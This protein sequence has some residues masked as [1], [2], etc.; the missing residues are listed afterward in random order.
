[1]NNIITVF[2]PVYNR[3]D[4]LLR[5]YESLICQTN[6]NFEWVICDDCSKDGTYEQ[7]KEWE[8]NET[9]F[10]IKVIKSATNGGKHRAINLGIK[11]AQGFMFFI[12]DS[13][14]CLTENAIQK[15]FDWEKTIYGDL[16]F[17]GL[18]F[19]KAD[20]YE[21]CVGTTFEGLIC[22]CTSLEREMNCITGDKAEVFYTDVIK[23]YP[24]P[25]FE[26]EKFLTEAVV[27]N[28]IAYDGLKIRWINEIIY[29]C[30]YQEDGLSAQ[31]HKNLANNPEG[32][33][34]LIKQEMQH[35]SYEGYKKFLLVYEYYWTINLAKKYTMKYAC[36]K[37]DYPILK[38]YFY[39][40]IRKVKRI[41]RRLRDFFMNN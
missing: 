18:G 15:I 19:L 27:W 17:A 25:T 14:D 7:V 34:F 40:P 3:K 28:A 4:L 8:K 9:R 39:M 1:M 30:E 12:V 37:L 29:L 2:T 26:G 31:W 10:P 36:R 5:L 6:Y 11:E 16:A 32:Y 13:D 24:F 38:A 21:K 33:A 20:L 23:K 22:D 41:F 35:K